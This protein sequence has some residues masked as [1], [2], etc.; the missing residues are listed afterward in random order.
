M[1]SRLLTSIGVLGV[2]FLTL[3]F[4]GSARMA[5][6]ASDW[7]QW[8]GPARD[9]I[10]RESG[11]L[12]QWPAGGPKLL[13]QVNDIRKR[14]IDQF[15]CPNAVPARVKLLSLPVPQLPTASCRQCQRPR[16]STNRV[17]DAAR[18]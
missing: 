4:P 3:S 16:V 2:C 1:K 17:S 9:G 8:R 12:K 14:V 13:W 10:S 5:G 6:S 7:P 18:S 15:I 11:L